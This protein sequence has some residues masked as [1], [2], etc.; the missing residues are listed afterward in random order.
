MKNGKYQPLL[1]QVALVTGASSGIGAGVAKALAKTRSV[2]FWHGVVWIVAGI[3][4]S[5]RLCRWNCGEDG[6][7][8]RLR[9]VAV[10]CAPDAEPSTRKQPGSIVGFCRILRVTV[11]IVTLIREDS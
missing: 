4:D 6:A 5:F 8:T 9:V 11:A 10:C 3:R 1:G 2:D 7:S